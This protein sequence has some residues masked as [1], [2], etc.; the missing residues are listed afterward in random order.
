V[1]PDAI[2]GQHSKPGI[3]FRGDMKYVVVVR[4]QFHRALLLRFGIKGA[5][6]E[7]FRIHGFSRHGQ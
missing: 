7:F 1:R 2:V 6:G 4:K 5:T 3:Q